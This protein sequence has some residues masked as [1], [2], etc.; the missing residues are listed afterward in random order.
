MNKPNFYSIL[1]AIIR[2]DK[3]LT[4]KAKLI[5]SEI[6]SL[7]NA[8]GECYAQNSY[9]EDLYNLS[10]S[11]ITRIIRQLKKKGYIDIKYIYKNDTK[12]IEKRVITLSQNPHEEVVSK[13]T[14]GGVKNDGD[15]NIKKYNISK[16]IL[17]KEKPKYPSLDEAKAYAKKREMKYID[18]EYFY[19]YFNDNNWIDSK[20]RK[21]RSW[22]QRMLTWEKHEKEKRKKEDDENAKYTR[23]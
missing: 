1:P 19:N 23:I 6:T 11:T 21:V 7:C 14:V 10:E 12:E 5:F 13:M 20:G 18:C 16:D 8:S 22:K 9:F 17:Y 15:N 3:D 2:Y 4:D